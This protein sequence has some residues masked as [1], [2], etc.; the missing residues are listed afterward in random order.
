[1][2]TAI[3]WFAV[4]EEAVWVSRVFEQLYAKQA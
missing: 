1:M 4:V 2:G 3:G